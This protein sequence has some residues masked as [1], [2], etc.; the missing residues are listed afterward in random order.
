MQISPEILSYDQFF[1]TFFFHF[2]WAPN[3]GKLKWEEL[4]H[5]SGTVRCLQGAM[6]RWKPSF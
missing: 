5:L 2:P 6:S 4:E 3:Q 1:P